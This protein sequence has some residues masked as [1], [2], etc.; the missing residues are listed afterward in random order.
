MHGGPWSGNP[1]ELVRSIQFS[2]FSAR[3]GPR[4]KMLTPENCTLK[5]EN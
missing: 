4:V 5:T 2:V 3:I 1:G